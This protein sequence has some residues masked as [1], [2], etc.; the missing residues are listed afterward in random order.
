MVPLPSSAERMH[1]SS[2]KIVFPKGPQALFSR[3]FFNT[4]GTG[5]RD[6]PGPSAGYRSRSPRPIATGAATSKFLQREPIKNHSVG[7]LPE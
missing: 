7:D 3:G 6:L 2:R 1:A 4:A 5:N